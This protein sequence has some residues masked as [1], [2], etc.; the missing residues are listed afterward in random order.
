MRKLFPFF[1]V[2]FSFLIF[3]NSQAAPNVL[4]LNS[5]DVGAQCVQQ[6]LAQLNI[7]TTAATSGLAMVQGSKVA[8]TIQRL[9]PASM[10]QAV[11]QYCCRNDQMGRCLCYAKSH[12]ECRHTC[13]WVSSN[14]TIP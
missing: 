12:N 4:K 13:G 1:I 10:L 2:L 14:L 6:A 5:A 9:C 7:N 3:T 8:N 11:N